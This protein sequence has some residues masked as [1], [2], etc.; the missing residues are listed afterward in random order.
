MFQGELNRV[1]FLYEYRVSETEIKEKHVF[2]LATSR[3]QY[4]NG[5]EKYL[6]ITDYSSICN[7]T[8]VIYSTFG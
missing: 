5:I 8:C 1:Y 6:L 4:I 2:H 7:K 3:I